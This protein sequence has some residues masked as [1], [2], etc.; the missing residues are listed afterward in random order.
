MRPPSATIP[1]TLVHALCGW[2]VAVQAAGLT[3]PQE[4]APQT[5]PVRSAQEGGSPSGNGD[6]FKTTILDPSVEPATRVTVAGLLIRTGT[7]ESFRIAADILETSPPVPS[8]QRAVCEALGRIGV[9][10]PEILRQPGA[11]VLA[12]AAARL[13]SADDAELRVRAAAAVS[14]FPLDVVLPLAGKIALNKEAPEPQ[15]LAAIDAMA[16]HVQR[17]EVVERLIGLL[18]DSSPA[19]V[20]RAIV[21]LTPLGRSVPPRVDEWKNWWATRE[22]MTETE[23]L[24]DRVEAL[25][26]RERNLENQRNELQS[27]LDRM[28]TT[29]TAKVAEL[30]GDLL[31]ALPERDRDARL[32][33]WLSDPTPAVCGGALQIVL[34]RISDSSTAPPDPVHTAIIKLLQHASPDVRRRALQVIGATRDRAD[35]QVVLELVR[36][37]QDATTRQVGL[38]VL[39]QLRN[40]DAIPD[41]LR[42]IQSP[43]STDEHVAA[44]AK[45]LA[46]IAADDDDS[47]RIRSED[48]TTCAEA[49]KARYLKLGESGNGTRVQLLDGLSAIAVPGFEDVFQKALDRNEPAFVRPAIRGM[50]RLSNRSRNAQIRALTASSDPGLR[51]LACEA[52][53]VLG[54]EPGDLESLFQR[55]KPDAEPQASIRDAAWSAF[56]DL[57]VRQPVDQQWFWLDRLSDMPSLKLAYFDF[58]LGP[59]S[60]VILDAE[61]LLRA[62]RAQC[63]VLIALNRWADAADSMLVVFSSLVAAGD[64]SA[65]EV[66]AGLVEARLRGGRHDHMGELIE[67]VLAQAPEAAPAITDTVATYLKSDD[68]RA[69]RERTARLIE[70]LR[71]VHSSLLGTEWD[72]ILNEAPEPRSGN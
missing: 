45:A 59:N 30:Q 63:G 20:Q 52:L 24:V 34:R 42:E 67:R 29:V 58:L 3:A 51:L 55:L 15:R 2:M 57:L 8:A 38:M 44:A 32:I 47:G 60:P 9:E 12:T 64:P 27:T 46:E 40:P 72:K 16:R 21:V 43:Q 48:L 71:T 19:V 49:I 70:Q 23:W 14:V 13:L 4:S 56:R 31:F 62:R 68:A 5:L 1:V 35:A 41:L 28:N 25:S 39:G 69:D 37:E 54:N 26:L 7:P 22:R 50:M 33:A 17:R 6:D 18:N 53:G 65:A 10:R 66:G 11:D 61:S 36:R